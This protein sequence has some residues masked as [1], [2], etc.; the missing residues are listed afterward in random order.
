MATR[1]GICLLD[2]GFCPSRFGGGSAIRERGGTMM[3]P[4][5]KWTAARTLTATLGLAVLCG[6][7]ACSGIDRGGVQ[8]GAKGAANQATPQPNESATA[9]ASA[10]ATNDTPAQ[11]GQTP[12]VDGD[13][14]AIDSD[15]EP[16]VDEE[17]D[18]EL[19]V[20]AGS[21]AVPPPPED[22]E[23]DEEDDDD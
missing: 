9:P 23:E 6:A 20:D 22:D 10:P 18:D 2:V 11:T 8:D 16:V 17:S 3:T 5:Q 7:S 4:A 1:L 12:E 21:A 13:A 19:D 15:E 14:G